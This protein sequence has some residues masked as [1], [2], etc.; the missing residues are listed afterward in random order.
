LIFSELSLSTILIH[1]NPLRHF[2]N[3]ERRVDAYLKVSIDGI[4]YFEDAVGLRWYEIYLAEE[5]IF[6]TVGGR[7]RNFV[8]GSI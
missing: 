3:S 7:Y 2:K 4:K 5:G 8:N 1:P 6:L